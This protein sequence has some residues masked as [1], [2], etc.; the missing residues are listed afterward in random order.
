MSFA[1][2]IVGFAIVVIG[3]IYGAVLLHVPAH[4]IVVGGLVLVGA[5]ILMGVKATRQKDSAS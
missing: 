2:Y 4:W 1:I 5:G 3:L